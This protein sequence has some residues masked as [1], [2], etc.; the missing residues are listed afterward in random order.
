VTPL[1]ILCVCRGRCRCASPFGL[2]S[3]PFHKADHPAIHP[4]NCLIVFNCTRP[5]KTSPLNS[6]RFAVQAEN[7]VTPDEIFGRHS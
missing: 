7:L 2:S 3:E 1:N 4:T 6:D 5:L